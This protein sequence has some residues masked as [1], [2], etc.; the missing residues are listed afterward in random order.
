M[1]RG[2]IQ[3]WCFEAAETKRLQAMGQKMMSMV[4][5][6]L[7]E[8]H[9]ELAPQRLQSTFGRGQKRLLSWKK[10]DSWV[11][12]RPVPALR[13]IL[14]SELEKQQMVDWISCPLM[15]PWKKDLLRKHRQ[16]SQ[17]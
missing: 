2:L 15:N 6:K 5:S 13:L 9:F 17:S 12:W 10:T 7:L 1:Q 11:V 14:C 16:G 3:M 4:R 8:Q